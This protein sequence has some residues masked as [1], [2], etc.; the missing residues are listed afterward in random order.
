MHTHR[1]SVR[2]GDTDPA[3][4]VYY[5]NL[6]HYF[7]IAMEEF[8]KHKCD[9]PYQELITTERVGFPTIKVE[10]EFYKPLVYGDDIE[11]TVTVAALG[12]S[13]VT[14]D[15]RVLRLRDATLCAQSKQVHVA[16]D[17]DSR[18]PLT[19]PDFLR[20]AFSEKLEQLE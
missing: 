5:P 6:F 8:F 9:S 4:L 11:I 19:I 14:L 13:S 17:L 10:A 15:Y 3:G 7:H 12:N 2:F 16:M 18:R 1:M 20:K